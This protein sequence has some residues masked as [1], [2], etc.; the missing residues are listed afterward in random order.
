MAWKA[1]D[2]PNRT[3]LL[4][5]QLKKWESPEE[6]KLAELDGWDCRAEFLDLPEHD[7]PMLT[8][9]LNKVGVWSPDVNSPVLSY[10][11]RPL[12]AQPEDIW[13]FREDLK[14]ALI[15]RKHFMSGVAPAF[16][17]PKTLLDL[18]AQS[19]SAND[20][21]LHFELTDVA[22]GVVTISNARHMLFATVLTDAANGIRFKICKRKDCG[23][24][25]PIESEHERKFC[26]QY[27]GHLWSVRN[28]REQERQKRKTRTRLRSR[29][30]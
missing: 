16:P 6:V 20:F 23:K 15:H 19:H 29:A 7:L 30:V 1:I 18:I 13:R 5:G 10:W 14:D 3:T 12:Y 25:Y 4:C 27:C 9:F 17:K 26:T 28:K 24:A 11:D 2:G 22:A 21:A 8:T